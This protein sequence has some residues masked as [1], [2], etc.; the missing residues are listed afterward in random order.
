MYVR[1]EK[2]FIT[3]VRTMAKGNDTMAVGGGWGEA[4]AAM[5]VSAVGHERRQQAV[6]S[7]VD[8]RFEVE[9]E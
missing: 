3:G 2:L 8:R 9:D 1:P 5:L 6:R 4:R 7:V